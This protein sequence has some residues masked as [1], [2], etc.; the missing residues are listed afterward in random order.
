M[1]AMNELYNHVQK[2][3]MHGKVIGFSANKL[4]KS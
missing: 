4:T 3:S 1:A 2:H